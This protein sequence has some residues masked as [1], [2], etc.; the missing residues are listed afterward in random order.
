[1]NIIFQETILENWLQLE[2]QAHCI[3]LG[4]KISS[5]RGKVHL[6]IDSATFI[7]IIPKPNKK[8]AHFLWKIYFQIPV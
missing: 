4:E 6:I 8:L 3:K 7:S 5:M 1:M 2:K